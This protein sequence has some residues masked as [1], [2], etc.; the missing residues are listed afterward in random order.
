MLMAKVS[1]I[2]GASII[3]VLVVFGYLSCSTRIVFIAVI[4]VVIAIT[5][6][7]LFAIKVLR[8][9]RLAISEAAEVR[10]LCVM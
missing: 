8:L 3:T 2:I 6:V 4:V 1:I 9:Y 7:F 5:V 10:M